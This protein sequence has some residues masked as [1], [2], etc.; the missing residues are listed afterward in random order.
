MPSKSDPD[1]TPSRLSN[2]LE[3]NSKEGAIGM[4][5]IDTPDKHLIMVHAR[6]EMEAP[7][8]FGRQSGANFEQYQGKENDEEKE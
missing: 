8:K 1:I 7:Q 4:N 2:V 5:H 3:S 6:S